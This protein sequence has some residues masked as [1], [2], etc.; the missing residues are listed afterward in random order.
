MPS[1]DLRPA[2]AG[3]GE[4][5]F[6]GVSDRLLRVQMEA[7]LRAIADSGLDPLSSTAFSPM[8]R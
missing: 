4:A 1:H 3:I 2:I 8:R 6:R 5:F 7:I